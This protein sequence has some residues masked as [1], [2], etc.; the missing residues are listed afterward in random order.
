MTRYLI[1]IILSILVEKSSATYINV[2]KLGVQI[3]VDADQS[4]LIQKLAD[5]YDSLFFPSG[6]YRLKKAVQLKSR[7]RI[8]GE[9][10]SLFL[11]GDEDAAFRADK[12]EDIYIAAVKFKSDNLKKLGYALLAVEASKV[13]VENVGC[14]GCGIIYVRSGTDIYT[15]VT[16]LSSDITI[17]GCVADAKGNRGAAAVQLRYCNNWI[18]K[19]NIIRG[20]MHGIQFWGGDSNPSR[21]GDMKNA[22]KCKGG[23]VVNNKVSDVAGGIWGSMGENIQVKDCIV[24][25]CTDVGI[26]F[27]GCS[28]CEADNNT[29]SDCHNGCLTIFFYNEDILFKENKVTQT[30]TAFPLACIYNATQ[31]QD[32]QS[33]TFSR[34]EFSVKNGV[35]IIYQRGP[36]SKLLFTENML[37]NVVT[38]FIFNNNRTIEISKNKFVLSE[39]DGNKNFIIR[40]GKTNNNGKVIITQN[41]FSVTSDIAK[42]DF[43]FVDIE[44]ADYNSSPTNNISANTFNGGDPRYYIRVRWNGQN[45]GFKAIN[46]IQQ[47]GI[48]A[49]KI[50]I[51]NDKNSSSESYLNNLRID[52]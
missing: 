16:N 14:E 39:I 20:Y 32:N 25:D 7:A 45:R 19:D 36:V 11:F 26:D 18:V 52:E 35:G 38:D 22:R 44:Q 24:T 17:K 10:E 50:L 31:K 47:L 42:S 8:K 51:V 9:A 13:I 23:T 41:Q 1:F 37:Y 43:Y 15:Q 12:V 30:N 28:K 3:N 6:Y 4:S 2:T 46:K 33:V 21:D 34:N 40:A 48:D 5:R 29:V 27:E 49:S